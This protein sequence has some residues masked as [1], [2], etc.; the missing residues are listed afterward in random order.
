MASTTY[1]VTQGNTG[2][3]WEVGIDD[4]ASGLVTLDVNYTCKLVVGT[5][6]DRAITD[7]ATNRFQAQL[8]PAETAALSL[9]RHVAA[10]EISNTTTTP[11][12]FKKEMQ[13]EILII[14]DVA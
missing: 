13:L 5:S 14:N 8:T 10:V 11:S 4:G 12:P 9:G 6:V 2:P 1:T 3:L 7:T